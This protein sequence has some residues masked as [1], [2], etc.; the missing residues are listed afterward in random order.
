MVAAAAAAASRSLMRVTEAVGGA[1]PSYVRVLTRPR[2][3]SLAPQ[4][5][6]RVVARLRTRQEAAHTTRSLSLSGVVSGPSLLSPATAG[7]FGRY[8]PGRDGQRL[9]GWRCPEHVCR[10]PLAPQATFEGAPTDR[11]HYDCSRW[12][13][14]ERLQARVLPRG[15]SHRRRV[16]GHCDLR[17]VEPA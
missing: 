12:R 15:M 7:L 6:V 1:R 10:G 17:G 11:R 13:E 2:S 14:R 5:N 16:D 3:R 8:P 4:A 9:V